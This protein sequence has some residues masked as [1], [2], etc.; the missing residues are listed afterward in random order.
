[1]PLIGMHQYRRTGVQSVWNSVTTG[2]IW[3]WYYD[4]RRKSQSIHSKLL[5]VLTNSNL[6]THSDTSRVIQFNIMVHISILTASNSDNNSV[7]EKKEGTIH[8]M[9]HKS[10]QSIPSR[11]GYPN[12][13]IP[14]SLVLARTG[15]SIA[16]RDD[17]I[18]LRQFFF[19]L[20]FAQPCCDKIIFYYTWI[21]HCLKFIFVHDKKRRKDEN[22]KQHIDVGIQTVE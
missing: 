15:A 12:G 16:P 6:Q 17:W 18:L 11:T 10:I 8:S 14:S 3:L 20:L 2:Y 19:H 7:L 4:C 1:M 9:N 21:F 22:T 13:L 5:Y